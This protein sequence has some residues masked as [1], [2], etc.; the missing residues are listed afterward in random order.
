MSNGYS[1]GSLGEDGGGIGGSWMGA[2]V[3][4]VVVVVTT[5]KATPSDTNKTLIR[6]TTYVVVFTDGAR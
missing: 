5:L 4:V 6:E 1:F 3:V 2:Y